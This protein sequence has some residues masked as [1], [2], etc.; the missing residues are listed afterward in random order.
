MDHS[1]ELRTPLVDAWLLERVKAYLPAFAR[2]P[3]KQ[4][5]AYAPANPMPGDVVRRR[6]TG[7]GIPVGR[8]LAERKPGSADT[9]SRGWA[10]A[11]TRAYEAAVA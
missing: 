1:V 10:K 9:G 2:F 5:L 6:K 4:L 11:L 8:W 3:S 7:F